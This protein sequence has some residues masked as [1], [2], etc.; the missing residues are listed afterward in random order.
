MTNASLGNVCPRCGK[1]RIVTKVYKEK[2]ASGYVDCKITACSDPACQK[3]V[4]EKLIGEE[5]KRKAIKK[6]QDRREEERQKNMNRRR[7]ADSE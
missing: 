2:T 7:K 6:E 4:D 5:T 3:I 1:D